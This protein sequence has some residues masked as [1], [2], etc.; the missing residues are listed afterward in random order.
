MG[1]FVLFGTVARCTSNNKIFGPIRTATRQRYYVID[2]VSSANFS[3]AIIALAFL[4]LVLFPNIFGGMGA[5]GI[6]FE[7]AATLAHGFSGLWISSSPFI[8][9]QSRAFGIRGITSRM[10]LLGSIFVGFIPCLSAG[11]SLLWISEVAFVFALRQLFFVGSTIGAIFLAFLVFVGGS[12]S[13]FVGF[14]FALFATM[15]KSINRRF[16]GLKIFSCRGLCLTTLGA[17]F[18]GIIGAHRNLS[19]LCQAGNVSQTLP[20][21]SIGFTPVSIPCFGAVSQ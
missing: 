5:F 12:P 7:S 10:I 8:E 20:G 15:A 2:M 11:L 13:R 9:L 19:F 21:I 3:S 1:K 4:G 16:A 17:S 18:R 6:A 14:G